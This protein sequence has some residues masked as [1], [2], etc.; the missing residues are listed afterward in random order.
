MGMV[1]C[2]FCTSV[3]KLG[4]IQHIPTND[5]ITLLLYIISLIRIFYVVVLFAVF[6]YLYP[7]IP[8]NLTINWFFNLGHWKIWKQDIECVCFITGRVSEE[9]L[10]ISYPRSHGAV[11]VIDRLIRDQGQRLLDMLVYI[12]QWKFIASEALPN[13]LMWKHIRKNI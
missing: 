11:W 13:K 12:F 7:W 4:F 1:M 2:I 5:R 9:I 3:S 10:A 8:W 6:S